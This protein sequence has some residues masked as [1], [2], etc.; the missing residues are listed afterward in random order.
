[1]RFRT[2]SWNS[3]FMYVSLVTSFS[4]R[5]GIAILCSKQGPG[6]FHIH[7]QYKMLT[8]LTDPRGLRQGRTPLNSFHFHA[9]FG[10]KW[11]NNRFDA[12]TFLREVMYLP[13]HVILVLVNFEQD[14]PYYQHVCFKMTHHLSCRAVFTSTV[15]TP[16]STADSSR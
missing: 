4:W 16:T 14:L 5:V 15:R 11:P 7:F 1:M 13:L 10:K 12:F 6:N 8:S 3:S 9:V 2:K